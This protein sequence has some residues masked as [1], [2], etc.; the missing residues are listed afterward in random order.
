[1]RT[2]GPGLELRVE[3]A[4]DEPGMIRQLDDLD[5]AADG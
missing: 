2:G 4:A 3:L 5:Q 1:M